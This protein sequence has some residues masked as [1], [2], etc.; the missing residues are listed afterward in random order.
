MEDYS[1]HT[2]LESALGK[3]VL[4]SFSDAANS[5]CSIIFD[6]GK[7]D[8]CNGYFCQYDWNCASGCCWGNSCRSD[9]SGY[10][11]VWLWWTLSFLFLFCCICSMIGA[12]K[13]RRRM[14][15][16]QEAHRRNMIANGLADPT[17]VVVTQ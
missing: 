6:S 1:H 14:L 15:A 11:L 9:C 7:S 17:I 10:D 8:M 13:R 5:G 12:A 3:T 16:L 4:E 2:S